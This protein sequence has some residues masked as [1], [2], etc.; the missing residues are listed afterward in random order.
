MVRLVNQ[1]I[2]AEEKKYKELSIR[3]MGRRIRVLRE[4]Q[5]RTHEELAEKMGISA[6]FISDVEYGN[7]GM[8]IKNIYLLAQLLGVTVDYLLD[9][10][11]SAMNKDAEAIRI[12]EEMLAALSQCNL[13]QLETFRRICQIYV[14]DLD[15]AAR[16]EE[17]LAK[18]MK[19]FERDRRI[20]F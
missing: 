19:T 3:A 8:S 7:R 5:G 14:D 10:S 20:I 2:Q 4:D 9:G 16:Q 6:I 11:Q 15:K 13:D 17:E 18:A 12:K 1:K